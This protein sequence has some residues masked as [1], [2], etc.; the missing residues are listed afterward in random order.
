M[1]VEEKIKELKII[2][3]DP[4]DPVGAYLA[5]RKVGNFLFISGQIS[6]DD[7]GQ[8]IKNGNFTKG[9]PDD[10]WKFYDENGDIVIDGILTNGDFKGHDKDNRVIRG[11]I[12]ENL[13][14][15]VYENSLFNGF[16]TNQYKF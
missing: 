1:T 14:L 7:N 5:T 8:L 10:N 13:N 16:I 2:L 3:P 12:N 15:K 6:I 4:K 9:V 11:R